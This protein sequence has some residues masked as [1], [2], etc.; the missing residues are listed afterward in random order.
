[1]RLVVCLLALV[2]GA[3][4]HM[5][6][7]ELAVG[8][9]WQFRDAPSTEARVVIT[10]IEPRG[11]RRVVHVSV[12]GLPMPSEARELMETMETPAGEVAAEP[13]TSEPPTQLILGG[14]FGS[15]GEWYGGF[16]IL[17]KATETASIPHVAAYE[18]DLR[19]GL[20]EMTDTAHQQYEYFDFAYQLWEQG[21]RE[22]PSLHD[23]ELNIPLGSRVQ[24][25]LRSVPDLLQTLRADAPN[26][27]Q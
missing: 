20:T 13:A 19:P 8:Q 21:E 4:A 16:L 15:E 12:V 7:P 27:E 22:W 11:G 6:Q 1:M 3:C 18:D 9:A 24:D 14:V 10:R 25:A 2:L 23:S 5:N 26:S 17:D